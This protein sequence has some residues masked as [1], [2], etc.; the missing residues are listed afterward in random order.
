MLNARIRKR[1]LKG[2]LKLRVIGEQADL[3]Y[4]Y[5][6]L[7]AGPDS[8]AALLKEPRDEAVKKPLIIIGQ[9][10]LNRA[11]GAAILAMAADLAVKQGAIAEGWNGFS[12]LH[13]EAGLV[14]ALDLGFVPGEGGLIRPPC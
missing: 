1:Y 4:P 11:D 13:T 2:G 8:L 9:G 14:G 12:V 3:S 10:A 7:G 6:Y 5:T